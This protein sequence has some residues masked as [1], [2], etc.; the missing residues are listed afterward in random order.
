MDWRAVALTVAFAVPAIWLLVALHGYYA[1]GFLLLVG[2][3]VLYVWVL[4]RVTRGDR[5]DV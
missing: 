5:R 4:K 1:Q 2:W 3:L